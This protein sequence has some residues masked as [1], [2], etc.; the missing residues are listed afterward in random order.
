MVV[1]V[2]LM[3]VRRDHPEKSTDLVAVGWTFHVQAGELNMVMVDRGTHRICLIG[4]LP[5]EKLMGLT[6]QLKF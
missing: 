3:F 2:V 1:V 6:D 5:A 4:A